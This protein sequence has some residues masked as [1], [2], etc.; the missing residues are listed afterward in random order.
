VTQ[1]RPPSERVDS[2]LS[3]AIGQFV[4]E[5]YDGATMEAIAARAGLTKGGLYHHF[6]S[7]QDLLVAVHER[8]MQPVMRLLDECAAAESGSEGLR[9]FIDGYVR[10][11]CGAPEELAMETLGVAKAL[12]TPDWH[13]DFAQHVEMMHGRLKSLYTRAVEQG[14]LTQV[15]PGEAA[16]AL[17][18]ALEGLE[19]YVTMDEIVPAERARAALLAVFVERYRP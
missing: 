12:T 3:A 5:G 8:L 15:D 9:R 1:K 11:S 4:A 14:E 18:G 6:S 19:I 13:P 2:I 17:F 10:L 7:K 16:L